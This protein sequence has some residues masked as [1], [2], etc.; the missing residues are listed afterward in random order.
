MKKTIS[1]SARKTT[2]QHHRSGKFSCVR[3]LSCKL[4][5]SATLSAA[6]AAYGAPVEP[7]LNA[8]RARYS[9]TTI[10]F[11]AERERRQKR[12]NFDPPRYVPRLSRDGSWSTDCEVILSW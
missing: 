5:E 12:V 3:Q 4:F 1:S 11:P 7:V 2:E 6:S 8:E 9:I 10:G